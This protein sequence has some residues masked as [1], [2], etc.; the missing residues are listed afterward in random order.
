M[1]ETLSTN[2]WDLKEV[3]FVLFGLGCS[4]LKKKQ[5]EIKGQRH[6]QY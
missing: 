2:Y 4:G 3:R 5:K 6:M 1:S